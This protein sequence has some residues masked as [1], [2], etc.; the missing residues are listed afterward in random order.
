LQSGATVL[1]INPEVPTRAT[2]PLY[3][4]GAKAGE[5]LPA[6]VDATWP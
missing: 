6:L 1:L 3:A 2:P 5:I 4:I